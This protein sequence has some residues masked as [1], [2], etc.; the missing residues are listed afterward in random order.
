MVVVIFLTIFLAHMNILLNFEVSIIILLKW[1]YNTLPW[2]CWLLNLEYSKN[3]KGV[4]K[5]LQNT[6]LVG[7]RSQ[8]HR[9]LNV[10]Q[11]MVFEQDK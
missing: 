5:N 11:T 7:V 9:Y 8:I 10:T 1:S 6:C 4:V 2:L 3:Y